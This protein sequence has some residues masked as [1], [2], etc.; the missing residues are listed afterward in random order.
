MFQKR[1]LAE[2]VKSAAPNTASSFRL[3]FLPV[4]GVH[5][6]AFRAEILQGL[7]AFKH[8]LRRVDYLY[9]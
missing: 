4:F 5:I 6:V 1:R 9:L 2:G 8:F 3:E 7:A